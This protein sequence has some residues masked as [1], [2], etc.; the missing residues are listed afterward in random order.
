MQDLLLATYSEIFLKGMN[1]PFFLNLLMKRVREAIAPLGAEASLRD[2]RI[3]VRGMQDPEACIQRLTKVFGIHSVSP[4]VEMDKKNFEAVCAAAVE[5]VKGFTGT[6]KVSARRSDKLYGLDSPQICAMAGAYILQRV[7][8]LRVDVKQPEHTVTIEIRDQAFLYVQRFPGVGGMPV[9]S[10]GRA[11]LMLSGGIDSPVAGYL[12]AKR[13]VR[14]LAV[15]FFSFPYTGERSRQK[16]YSLASRLAEYSGGLKLY[17]VPFTELQMRIHEKCPPGYSTLVMRRVMVRIAELIA[18]RERAQALV[19]GES[20]GQVASQTMEALV[21]TDAAAH[22]PVFRPLIGFD[23]VEIIERA[24]EIG[25]YAI[26]CLPY[27]DCCTVFTPRHPVTRPSLE[28]VEHAESALGEI[29]ELVRTAVD[30]AE[31]VFFGDGER[32]PEPNA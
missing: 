21:C 9:G 1:R 32:F 2:S 20:I 12:T 25:T 19:T 27:E 5:M 14:I 8:G 28:K 11:L 7:P 22:R 16:V 3:L 17:V 24:K 23:K 31:T 18:D 15:H 30:S 10:N 13:G 4:A 26:S 6:F 29:T